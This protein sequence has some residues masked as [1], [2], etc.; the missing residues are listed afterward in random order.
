[1]MLTVF[2][3]LLHKVHS[4]NMLLLRLQMMLALL[5]RRRCHETVLLALLENGSLRRIKL[6]AELGSDLLQ[7]LGLGCGRRVMGLV[8]RVSFVVVVYVICRFFVCRVMA[9]ILAV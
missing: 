9:V 1:M 2:D 8:C 5:L 6:S 7:V 3:L 4:N